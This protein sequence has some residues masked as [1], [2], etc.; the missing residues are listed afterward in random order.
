MNAYQ[1]HKTRGKE[2]IK[3]LEEEG[4]INKYKFTGNDIVAFYFVNKDMEID[5]KLDVPKEY[6]ICSLPKTHKTQY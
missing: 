5:C 2:I 3:L 1:G 6:K 4:G